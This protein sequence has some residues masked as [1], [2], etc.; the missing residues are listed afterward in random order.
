[1]TP[2]DYFKKLE[3]TILRNQELEKENEELKNKT[4]LLEKE[5]EDL[6]KRLL[7]YENPNTPHWSSVKEFS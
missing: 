4:E 6:K 5:N 7:F 1:M 2:D 3:D